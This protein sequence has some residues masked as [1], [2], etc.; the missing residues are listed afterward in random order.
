MKFPGWILLLAW[1]VG[2]GCGAGDQRAQPSPL[3]GSALDPQVSAHLQGLWSGV[4]A[5]P[6]DGVRRVDLALAMAVNGLWAEARD[7]FREAAARLPGDPLPA[8]YAAVALVEMG[9]LDVAVTELESVVA[10]FP[11]HA[12]SW[13]RLGL[14]RLRLGDGA[15]AARAMEEVTRLSPG[16]WRGW[17]GL[18]EVALREQRWEEAVGVLERAVD[19]DPYARSARHLLSQAY[20]GL[21]KEEWADREAAAGAGLV[22]GPMED[23]WSQR[24]LGHMRLLPDVYEQV[25]ALIAA[26]RVAEA[27]ALMEEARR[28][29]P[30]EVGVLV[31]L[32]R[33]WR[34]AG[35]GEEAWRRLSEAWKAQPEEV[36]LVMAASEA[37]AEVGRVEEA[38]ALALE[39]VGRAPRLAEAHVVL[40]NARVA[41]GEDEAALRSLETALELV[42]HH[43]DL[44]VQNGDLLWYNLE[45]RQEALVMYRRAR[46]RD[47]IHPVALHRLA[48]AHTAMGEPEVAR[49]YKEDME[50][51]RLP[52]WEEATQ[53]EGTHHRED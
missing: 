7:Q 49:R 27:V 26:G 20:R 50:R 1:L 42:P 2:G 28:H 3:N 5:H 6:R 21:G 44:M 19:L 52:P 9:H 23:A 10:A 14:V 38:L 35:R 45:R 47:P 31:R 18:G 24:A 22:L 40:A 33:A 16:E 4:Q 39:G 43:A 36:R 15:G 41:A 46:E 25:D 37:A 30:E 11:R 8:M 51:L 29:H 17:A 32:A 12:P 48:M 34:A 53:G 13:H